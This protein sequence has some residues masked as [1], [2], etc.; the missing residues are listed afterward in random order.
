MADTPKNPIELPY[1]PL[2]HHKVR[3]VIWVTDK[4]VVT[5]SSL[6]YTKMCTIVFLPVLE[7]DARFGV[8]K[9][10]VFEVPWFPKITRMI[11]TP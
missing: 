11:H 2:T 1:F 6:W 7:K 3:Y 5:W 10:K 8:W 4:I 9:K